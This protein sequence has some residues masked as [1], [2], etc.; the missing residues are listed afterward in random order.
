LPRPRC[1]HRRDNVTSHPLALSPHPGHEPTVKYH[2][3]H[4]RFTHR[5]VR[6]RRPDPASAPPFGGHGLTPIRARS[7][8]LLSP[9]RGDPGASRPVENP[10]SKEASRNRSVGEFGWGGT[11]V[12][13]QRWRPE[14]MLRWNRN[15]PRR[16]RPKVL[17]MLR[18]PVQ[19]PNV[20]VWP[21]DPLAKQAIEFGISKPEVSEKLPQG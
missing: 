13:S 3:L 21:S 11:P 17:L 9:R 2:Y 15:L 14:A 10:Q 5:V 19:V 20:Q 8:C 12:T 18:L 1:R 7:G 6:D 16:R 4:R